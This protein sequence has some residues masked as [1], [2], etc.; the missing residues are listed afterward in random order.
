MN[1]QVFQLRS[2]TRVWR[3]ALTRQGRLIAP[4]VHFRAGRIVYTPTKTARHVY[5]FKY[6][7]PLY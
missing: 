4:L 2:F 1:D 7:L 3:P 5:A 6:F